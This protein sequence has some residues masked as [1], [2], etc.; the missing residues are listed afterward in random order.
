MKRL[1]IGLTIAVAISL[2]ILIV[3]GTWQMQ[4]LAW[5]TDLLARIEAARTAEPVSVDEILRLQAA[6]QPVEWRRVRLSCSSA[7]PPPKAGVA[8]ERERHGLIYGLDDGKIAWRL[9]SPCRPTEHPEMTVVLDRGFLAAQDG[10]LEPQLIDAPMPVSAVGLVRLPEPT[11]KQWAPQGP[12]PSVPGGFYASHREAATFSRV[13][14][15]LAPSAAFYLAAEAETPQP[16]GLRPTASPPDIP[17]RH[18]E[19]ALTWFG[20]AG[21]LLAIYAAMIWRRFKAQ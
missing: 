21:A 15:G 19:Y 6:G 13:G 8:P 5:K 10:V 1:P 4:R 20:L 16:S 14:S 3:L 7:R 2:V 12:P 11:T 17:N 18:L 9:L